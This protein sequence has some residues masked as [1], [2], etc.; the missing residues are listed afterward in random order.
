MKLG[1]L[2]Y[3]TG[4]ETEAQLSCQVRHGPVDFFFFCKGSGSKYFRTPYDLLQY[5]SILS[6]IVK[7]AIGEIQILGVII[8]QYNFICG[9]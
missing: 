6:H 4:K 8:C 2:T 3:F 7:A 9:H 5:S 1:L